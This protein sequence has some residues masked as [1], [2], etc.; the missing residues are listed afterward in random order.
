MSKAITVLYENGTL[1]PLQKDLG[2]RE[3]AAVRVLICEEHQ[4]S[5]CRRS[6]LFV[7]WTICAFTICRTAGGAVGGLVQ[8]AQEGRAWLVSGGGVSLA[9]E[10]GTGQIT[11]LK[12]LKRC[13]EL[14]RGRGGLHF[15][16][17]RTKQVICEG[18]VGDSHLTPATLQ[19]DWT[20]NQGNLAVQHLVRALENRILWKATV[21]NKGTERRLLELR[22][23][24]PIAVGKGCK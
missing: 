12:V 5:R 2:L 4:M 20:S 21:S 17:G 24:L 8:Q 23:G 3:G 18:K 14:G 7:L 1:R 11:G 16:D 6:A 19:F 15:I 10:S 22:L 13:Q 9:I